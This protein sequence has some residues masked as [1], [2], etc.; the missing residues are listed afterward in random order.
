MMHLGDKAR[1]IIGGEFQTGEI[2]MVKYDAVLGDYTAWLDLGGQQIAIPRGELE[3]YEVKGNIAGFVGR[4][5]EFSILEYDPY[6]EIYVASCKGAKLKKQQ[7]IAARLKEGETLEATILKIVYFGA[8][9]VIDCLTVILR[10]KDFSQDYTTVGDVFQKGDKIRVKLH[11]ISQNGKI[12]VQSMPKYLNPYRPDFSEFK[13]Q[14]VISGV[15]RNIKPWA[16]F[17]NIAPNLDAICP[18]PAQFEI[19]EGMLVA[20]RIHQVRPEDK[21]VRG[22]IIKILNQ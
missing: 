8:Y 19:G 16:C 7:E 9:L 12:N 14:M 10:N 17:V 1:P 4:I 5:V 20:F 11:R 15:V 21:K 3:L 2:R 22:K 6:R 13:P 18:M